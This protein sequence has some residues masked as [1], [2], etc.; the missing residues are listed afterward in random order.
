M[1]LLIYGELQ[2]KA[3]QAPP[4]K[5]LWLVV[6]LCPALSCLLLITQ[7]NRICGQSI[8]LSG[9]M[10]GSEPSEASLPLKQKA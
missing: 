7:Y 1:V 9:W 8:V 6:V 3:K 4:W 5:E 10:S 2:D